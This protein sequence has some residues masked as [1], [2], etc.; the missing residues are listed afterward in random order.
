MPDD[1]REAV[2]MPIYLDENGVPTC[3]K[4]GCQDTKVTHSYGW[5]ADGKRRRRVC[6]NC[7]WVFPPSVEVF[8]E[9]A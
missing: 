6:T 5:Q 7:R 9:M 8:D 3:P 1:N 4:C 2:R